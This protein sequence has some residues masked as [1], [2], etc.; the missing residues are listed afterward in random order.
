MNI[1]YTTENN[2]LSVSHNNVVHYKTTMIKSLS[3]SCNF[4]TI[5]K[6]AFWKNRI[7]SIN[8]LIN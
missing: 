8:K 7:S 4:K 1:A 2:D 6:Q 5:H 3:D